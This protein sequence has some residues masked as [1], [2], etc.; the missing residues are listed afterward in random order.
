MAA[1]L[2]AQVDAREDNGVAIPGRGPRRRSIDVAILDAGDSLVDEPM[3]K[4]RTY[5]NKE[6]I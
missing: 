5:D 3:P 2:R 6:K 1:V 4:L